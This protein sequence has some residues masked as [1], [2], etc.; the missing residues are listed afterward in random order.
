MRH[1]C[2]IFLFKQIHNIFIAGNEDTVFNRIII[3]CIAHLLCEMLS[4]VPR[5]LRRGC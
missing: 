5:R 3:I 1:Q 2:N 4:I